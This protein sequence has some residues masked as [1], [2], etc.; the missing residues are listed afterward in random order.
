MSEQVTRRDVV[1][2]LVEEQAESAVPCT[3]PSLFGPCRPTPAG[4]EGAP[5]G[6]CVK[7]LP[8]ARKG[9]QGKDGH[10]PTWGELGKLHGGGDL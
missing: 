6:G 8:E 4:P 7:L 10:S 3:W 2:A 9:V 5:L 1:V